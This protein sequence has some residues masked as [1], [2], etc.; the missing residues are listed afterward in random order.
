MPRPRVP[1]RRHLAPG[2]LLAG[3]ALTGTAL[4]LGALQSHPADAAP[5]SV[6][7]AAAHPS[8][9]QAPAAHRASRGGARTALRPGHLPARY[10]TRVV[11]VGR[12][13]SGTASW[14]GGSFQG[15]HT[16][17]GERFDTY[18]LTAASRTLPFGTRLRVCR[19]HRCVVVRVNDR[20]PYVGSRV[21]DLSRAA[22]D[23]L[24]HFGVARV[25]ATPVATRRVPV[26][27][28][29]LKRRAPVAPRPVSTIAPVPLAGVRPVSDGPQ[30]VDGTLALG[31]LLAVG[32]GL[33][34]LRRLR[35][36]S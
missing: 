21:L 23:R 20:G 18:E 2:G 33:A 13:F 5:R 28:T 17:N 16:A 3:L 35:P 9:L 15:R 25:T 36:S 24:G 32:S 29:V 11:P 12:P 31:T 1:A 14:Y 7:H 4:S 10:V 34:W 30:H 19:R 22:R 8:V 26:H 6:A 27:P